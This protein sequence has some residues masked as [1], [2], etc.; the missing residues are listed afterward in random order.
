MWTAA[1]ML[2]HDSAQSAQ[3]LARARAR[4]ATTPLHKHH[5][6][7][8]RPALRLLYTRISAHWQHIYADMTVLA[9][10]ARH[11][12]GTGAAPSTHDALESALELL[13]FT[14]D[15]QPLWPTRRGQRPATQLSR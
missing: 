1:H 12:P 5:S 7:M 13:H 15:L 2:R 8:P 10:G 6:E 3:R 9:S 11:R 4:G 14:E